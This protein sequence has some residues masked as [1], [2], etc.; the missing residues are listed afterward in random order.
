MDHDDTLELDALDVIVEAI[1]KNP[2][3]GLFYSDEDK[4]SEDGSKYLTLT[5]SQTG[6]HIYLVT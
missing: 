1:N 4:L 6:H 3:A 5:L 2:K